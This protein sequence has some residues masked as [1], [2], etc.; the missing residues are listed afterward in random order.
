[1]LLVP[2][3]TIPNHNYYYDYHKCYDHDSYYYYHYYY[4]D[5]C[6]YYYHYDYYC[7]Y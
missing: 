4:D 5:Y 7:E 1:M 3:T 2:T 6:C